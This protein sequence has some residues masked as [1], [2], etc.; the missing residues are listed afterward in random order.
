MRPIIDPLDVGDAALVVRTDYSD[1]AAWRAVVAL[2]DSQQDADVWDSYV[3]DEPSWAGASVEDV[4]A[5]APTSEDVVFIAD[6]MTMRSPCPFL[7][8]STVTR[9]DCEDDE[10]YE[11][12]LE[13]GRE[14]R[15]LPDGLIDVS[16]NLAIANMDFHEFAATAQNDPDGWYRRLDA[17][18]QAD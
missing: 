18:R 4:L 15:V 14:F 12:E 3:V 6:S 7:A 5:A 10:E 17:A 11:Y 1:D 8:V 2:L 9:E 13:Y 16:V